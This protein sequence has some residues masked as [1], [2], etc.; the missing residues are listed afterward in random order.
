MASE[1]RLRVDHLIRASDLPRLREQLNAL[2]LKSAAPDFWDDRDNAQGTL[3][4]LTALRSDVST[5]E[6]FQGQQEDLTLALELLELESDPTADQSEQQNLAAGE[7]A[8][9]AGNLNAALEQW[10]TRLLLGGPYDERGAVLTIQAG[11]GG[12]D[13]QDWAE[14]LERM[15]TRWGESQGY[16]VRVVD[17]AIG[18]VA[19]IK[20]V[21]IEM[22]GRYAYG[23][24]SGEKGTH[25]LVRQSPFNAKAARQTSF[26]A[27]E[28]MPTLDDVIAEVA[29]P[30]SDLEI[31]SMR[32]SGAGGQNVNKVETAVRIK[33][34]PTGLT[35]RCQ[36]ERSQ[37]MNKG[38]ALAILKA[39]LLVV[40]KEQ[41]ASAVASIRGDVVRAEWGQ[42]VR[43][44][45]FHPYKL[46]KDVRTGE[47]TSNISAVMDGELDP[48]LH[49]DV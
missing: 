46:V 10:E 37:V 36:E 20:S 14:M 39:R 30:D 19:G 27:V 16:S 22:H 21:E 9:I 23:L 8:A 7:A 4:T 13:A 44:Y 29:I 32:S 35:V 3:Q 42:Q 28:V 2:E 26:A 48:Y 24:L 38:R 43:N 12:A 40:A 45:V 6:R 34:I 31:S 15:Y 11:A 25:R 1:L 47:E 49:E 18:E 5:L 41:H 33:H 17:R